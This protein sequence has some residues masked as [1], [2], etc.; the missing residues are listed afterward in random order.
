MAWDD[1]EIGRLRAELIGLSSAE[2]LWDRIEHAAWLRYELERDRSAD[3]Q[4]EFR[5]RQHGRLYHRDYERDRRARG[6]TRPRVVR[7][8]PGCR[9]MFTLS[10]TQYADGTRFCSLACAARD[11]VRR[12]RLRPPRMVT[13]DGVTR[14]LPEWANH[15]GLTVSLVY[16]RMREEGMSDVEALQTPKRPPRRKARAVTIDGV[17]LPVAEWAARHGISVAMFYRR[18]REGMTERE[19]LMVPRLRQRCA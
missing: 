4:A 16:K 7:C 10:D 3:K 15:F 19:A 2:E 17:T 1:A 13:I 14:S 9:S 18:L 5:S 6:K 12:G 8:C 11:R